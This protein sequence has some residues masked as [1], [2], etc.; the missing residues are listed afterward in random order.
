MTLD[1][2][3]G[4]QILAQ[5]QLKFEKGFSAPGFSGIGEVTQQSNSEKIRG[6]RIYTTI[7]T[8]G[9]ASNYLLLIT[10]IP[11]LKSNGQIDGI[12]PSQYSALADGNRFVVFANSKDFKFY[13]LII[14]K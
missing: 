5:K 2:E 12:A 10:P 14:R 7:S 13:Y 9:S 6:K 3:E 8:S 1:A 11:K 4:S